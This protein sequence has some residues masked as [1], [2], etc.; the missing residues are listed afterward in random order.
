MSELKRI[1]DQLYRMFEA[2][3]WHGPSVTD[4]LADIDAQTAAARPIPGA[5][6]IW[7]LVAHLTV[8]LDVPR[9]RTEEMRAIEPTPKQ[10]W[11][12]VTETGEAAW[13]EAQDRL[14]QAYQG[15][16][17]LLAQLDEGRLEETAPGRDYPVYVL[18]HGV[19]QHLAYHS[20]QIVLL[21]KAG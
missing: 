6:S 7:E 14:R 4:A 18:L 11:P 15:L 21:K 10:D 19:I 16:R 3:P 2:H 5:H 20:G 1:D 9:R 12:P 8:W 17:D 13:R